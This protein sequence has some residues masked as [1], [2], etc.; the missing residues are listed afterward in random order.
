MRATLRIAAACALAAGLFACDGETASTPDDAGAGGAAGGAGGQM[1]VSATGLTL[2]SADE[3]IGVGQTLTLIATVAF[4][5]DTTSTE[6]ITWA[7]SDAEIASVEA[8]VITANMPG[9]AVITARY[10]D[11]TAEATVYVEEGALRVERVEVTGPARVNMGDTL[12]FGATA[13]YSDGS[14]QVLIGASYTADDLRVLDID[15]DSAEAIAGGPV[16]VSTEFEGVVGSWTG[17]VKCGE[18]PFYVDVLRYGSTA[19]PL[20]WRNAYTKDGE[21]FHFSLDDAR[22][23]ADYDDTSIFVIVMGAGWC[24]ACTQWTLLLDR[25]LPQMD[26]VRIIHLTGQTADFGPADSDYAQ[27]HL[28]RLIGTGHGI[29]V[30]DADT[31]IEDDAV[32]NFVTTQDFIEYFPTNWVIRRRDMRVITDSFQA[33]G[34]L[35]PLADIAAD[36]EADWSRPPAIQF[37]GECAEGVEE[38]TDAANDYFATAAVIGAGTYEGGICNDQADYY[39]IDIE[40]PWRATLTFDHD[41]GDLGVYAYQPR[42]DGSAGFEPVERRGGELVGSD[43]LT[44]VETFEHQGYTTIGING[45]LG[46]VGGAYT[47]EIEAL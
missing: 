39:R 13:H 46:A 1:A 47:L 42:R 3:R 22:C 26:G 45:F 6:G 30:G 43:T 34:R 15:G 25:W 27:A 36:P 35:L 32:P 24:P 23:F 29:R 41:E 8:G 33:G 7:S 28:D 38:A 11:F 16:T 21:Q 12:E 9:E 31:H 10:G 17:T 37:R 20:N 19:P 4:D 44:G 14:T 5:D 40:G 2:D 18:Y